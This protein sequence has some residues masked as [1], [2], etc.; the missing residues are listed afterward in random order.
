M[1]GRDA[2]RTWR[3]E[4][5]QIVGRRSGGRF[6]LCASGLVLTVLVGCSQPAEPDDAVPV[7]PEAVMGML[8][9]ESII[10]Y[11]PSGL[12]D[13]GIVE[14]PAEGTDDRNTVF[15]TFIA[16]S[17]EALLAACADYYQAALGED[18]EGAE[19]ADTNSSGIVSTVLSK[20][21]MELDISCVTTRSFDLWED[22]QDEVRLSVRLNT[23]STSGLPADGGET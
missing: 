15:R 13:Q 12:E 18:W 11:T 21:D 23:S 20:A 3:R 8:R 19:P 6:A 16:P 7:Q 22:D 14:S 5:N 2:V 1:K 9:N 4:G 17:D 10:D